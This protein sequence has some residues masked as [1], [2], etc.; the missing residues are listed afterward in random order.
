[1]SILHV[2]L[3][4]G[5]TFVGAQCSMDV[6]ASVRLLSSGGKCPFSAMT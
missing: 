5:S 6:A 2:I 3:L 4:I 1:M